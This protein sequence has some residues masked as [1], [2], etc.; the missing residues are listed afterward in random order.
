MRKNRYHTDVE[1]AQIVTLHKF[2]RNL[3]ST[4]HPFKEQ[5]KNS[6]RKEFKEIGKNGRPRKTTARDDTT[7]KRIVVR[8]PT[9]YCKKLRAHHLKIGTDVSISTVSRRLSEEF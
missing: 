6:P 1:C 9:S 8:S 7:M 2:R 5:S 4:G 3:V